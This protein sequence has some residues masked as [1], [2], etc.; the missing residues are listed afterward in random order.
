MVRVGIIGCGFIAHKHVQTIASMEEFSL[1]AVSDMHEEKMQEIVRV[2]EEKTGDKSPIDQVVNYENMLKDPLIDIIIVAVLSSLHAKVA[3]QAIN[4]GKHVIVEKPLSLS[5]TE[6]KQLVAHASEK[7]VHVL[8]CHQL[9]YSP[10]MQKIKELIEEGYF[11]EL[12]VGAI[13]L[14]LNRN[15]NYY[16]SADWKGSWEHDGGMLINQGIHLIDL[17]VWFMGNLESVY[18]D[19]QTKET[20]KETEDIAL[21]ICTFENDAKG[22]IE[23]NTITQPETVGYY[24]SIFGEKGSLSI[25][26]KRFNE[27]EHCYIEGQPTIEAEVHELSKI[28]D[29]RMRM[30]ENFYQ[31]LQGNEDLLMCAEEGIYALEAIFA[32]YASHQKEE[33]VYLPL[34]DFSTKQMVPKNKSNE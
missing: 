16:A 31:A 15:V 25:G 3:K 17:L 13:T 9:R 18:G 34:Q 26:G 27:I 2:Y 12:Y 4:H 7:N 21:G 6:A 10:L 8:V 28:T 20:Y 11:G 33:R 29:E 19:L 24:L 22:I 5:L 30:Y 1:V 14:R 23:A 32:L